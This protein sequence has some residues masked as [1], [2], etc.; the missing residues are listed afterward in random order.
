M[1]TLSCPRISSILTTI[2]SRPQYKRL[3]A[4]HGDLVFQAPRRY[5]LSYAAKTQPTYA[6]RKCLQLHFGSG[7]FANVAFI[8]YLKGF[9][10]PVVGVNHASDISFFFG[11]GV[12]DTNGVDSLSSYLSLRSTD[13]YSTQ[14]S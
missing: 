13:L 1:C 11:A 5:F 3:A 14:F 6:F 12:N 2:Q 4:F 8:G 9:G 10:T 7:T